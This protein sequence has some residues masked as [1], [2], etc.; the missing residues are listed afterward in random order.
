MRKRSWNV[1]SSTRSSAETT[2][3]NFGVG[4][5]SSTSGI[6][7]QSGLE[8]AVR[9]ATASQASHDAVCGTGPAVTTTFFGRGQFAMTVGSAGLV[10]LADLL[11]ERHF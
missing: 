11:T 2:V 6:A 3:S 10:G 7:A 4:A 5:M 8:W 1:R 9:Q